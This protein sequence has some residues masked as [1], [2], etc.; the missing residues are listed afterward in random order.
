MT[1]NDRFEE[2]VRSA[3]NELDPVPPVPRDAMWENIEAA[4]RFQR[5]RQRD[6]RRQ[7][8]AWAVALAAMLVIG[9]GL[10]RLSVTKQPVGTQTQVATADPNAQTQSPSNTPAAQ[11]SPTSLSERASANPAL[12]EPYRM[13][14]IEHLGRAEVLLTSVSSGN[15]DQQ[16]SGWAKEML[17]D[18]RLLIDSPA[19]SDPSISNLLKD[20][21]LLLAQIASTR[22]GEKT[23]AELDLIQNGI[24]ET[25]VLPRLRATASPNRMRVGT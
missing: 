13:A 22:P 15:V 11:P 16:L 3:V 4:R 9:I 6:H 23:E 17:V 19:A 21:E 24:K 7:Y 14:A 5:P 18:T 8:I 12:V 25:D 2:F 10:G 20:L 1:D